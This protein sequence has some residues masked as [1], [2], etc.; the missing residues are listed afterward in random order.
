ME[1]DINYPEIFECE[2]LTYRQKWAKAKQERIKNIKKKNRENPIQNPSVDEYYLSWHFIFDMQHFA[3]QI[4]KLKGNTEKAMQLVQRPLDMPLLITRQNN[5]SIFLIDAVDGEILYEFFQARDIYR[6]R[7]FKNK[8][9]VDNML[10]HRDGKPSRNY[11]LVTRE[12]FLAGIF[13]NW[14]QEIYDKNGKSEVPE[15]RQP[16]TYTFRKPVNQIDLESGEI[17]GTFPSA[18]EAAKH[19]G[20]NGSD[21]THCCRG[22]HK[23]CKGYGWKYV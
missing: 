3:N 6:A 23:T 9:V 20:C 1:I 8:K 19:V 14:L 11:Y 22:K 21:I 10:Y 15:P 13:P 2:D 17:L 5:K 12:N 16:V 7:I 4:K 18:A